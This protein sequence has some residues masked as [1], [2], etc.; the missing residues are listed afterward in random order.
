M[1]NNKY[2]LLARQA[3][4]FVAALI[5]L[6]PAMPV[7]AQEVE[8]SVMIETRDGERLATDIYFPEGPRKNLPAIIVRT[9]YGKKNE[10]G[11]AQLFSA[12]GFVTIIQDVRGRYESSGEYTV[13]GHDVEDSYDTI[14]WI[15]NQKWSNKKVGAYGCSYPGIVNARMVA[16]P[17]P[18]LK[19]MILQGAGGAVGSAGGRYRYFG[20]F[21]GGVP[22]LNTGVGWFSRAG[23]K[24]FARLPKNI[25]RE[26]YLRIID[27][28]RLSP[29]IP[30]REVLPEMWNS[31]P[32]AD[33]MDRLDVPPNDW[34]KAI[35]TPLDD[36]WWDQFDYLDGG[37]T[38]TMP[39][40]HVNSWFDYAAA[41]TPFMFNLFRKNA[42]N[43]HIRNS[44]FLVMAP[45]GHCAFMHAAEETIVGALN[46]GDA[47]YEYNRLWLDWFNH[48]LKEE[49]NA[50]TERAR[51]NFYLMG[52]NEWRTAQSWPPKD[53]QLT[54]LYLSSHGQANSRNGD[55]RLLF[56]RI[57]PEYSDS[58]TY[59]PMNPAPSL[60]G[61]ICCM[62][63][64][65]PDGSFDQS[66]VENRKD[67]LVYTSDALADGVSI[68][69][70]I[71]VILN[72]S[73]NAKDTDFTAKLVDVHPSGE[74]FNIQEGILRARYREGFDRQVFLND[75]EIVELTIDLQASAHHF[76]KGHRVRLEVSSSNFPRFERNLN[77]GGRNYDE[78]AGVEATNAVHHGGVY[79]SRLV[80]PVLSE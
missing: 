28:Y 72:V 44:Q 18:A 13:S 48:W 43:D 15:V 19:A 5:A 35:T 10:S 46:V 59:D 30:G 62:G 27:Q 33:I 45:T 80:L 22:N 32:S 24:N 49:K 65:S 21:N 69:G 58:F 25:P 68:A 8:R 4:L 64:A 66:E 75:G 52:K 79:P 74:A 47:R 16:K 51:V 71:K 70:P 57:E 17:H 63:N 55:G 2:R 26:T 60:G 23:M 54:P 7:H 42:V 53:V 3:V 78:V 9:P 1:K 41:E 34:K 50:V 20:I 11:P 61:P 14:S 36:P 37:E 67:I 39:V 38:V 40:L 29:S 56:T 12:N 77:T 31:L 73:S 6:H 76:A